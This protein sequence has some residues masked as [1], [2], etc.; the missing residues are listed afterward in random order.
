[1]EQDNEIMTVEEVAEYFKLSTIT[2]YKWLKE[3]S[4][5]GYKVGGNSWR[6]LKSDLEKMGEIT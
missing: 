6:I 3:G 2:V 5:P 4:I 1:M